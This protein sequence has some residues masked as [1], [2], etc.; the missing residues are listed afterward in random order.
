MALICVAA[1]YNLSAQAQNPYWPAGGWKLWAT[2]ETTVADAAM[3]IPGQVG[4]MA[5]TALTSRHYP[6]DT[7]VS[8]KFLNY[9]AAEYGGRKYAGFWDDVYFSVDGNADGTPHSY[10][11]GGYWITGNIN[12]TGFNANSW[13]KGYKGNIQSDPGIDKFG[14]NWTSQSTTMMGHDIANSGTDYQYGTLGVEKSWYFKNCL[15]AGPAHISFT[16]KIIDTMDDSYQAL[17]PSYFDSVGS[18]GSEVHGLLKMMIAGG[19]L[20][21][22]MKPELKRHGIYIATMLYIWKASLPYDAPYDSELRHRVAYSTNGDSYIAT[23]STHYNDYWHMYNEIDHMANMVAMAKTMTVAPPITLIK[24]VAVLSGTKTYFNKT[25]ALIQQAA[26]QQG[27][28][29]VSLNDSYDIASRP[30]TFRAK[31]LYGNPATVITEESPGNYLII[32]P[33]STTLPKGRTTIIFIANNGVYDSNPAVLNFYRTD[34][35]ANKRPVFTWAKEAIVYPGHMASF[36][37]KATDP[38]GFPCVFYKRTQDPGTITGNIYTL[39]TTG[40]AIGSYPIPILFSDSTSGTAGT[41][42][43]IT[44]STAVPAAVDELA[45]V[46]A[47]P[48]PVNISTGT[49]AKIIGLTGNCIVEIF[50]GNGT[51]VKEL[52]EAEQLFPNA[53]RVD[54]DGKNENGDI[55]GRG[56]YM[57]VVKSALGNKKTGKIAL[58]K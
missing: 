12:S 57:F 37:L 9:R 22:A 45:Q 1:A 53:G 7:A 13:L 43:T 34:G 24:E 32:V 36:E 14:V 5:T 46:K 52:K 19:Y 33:S 44:V 3:K 23:G 35:A 50:D 10:M 51:K 6:D 16:E 21:I 25:A 55:V 11:A 30:L 15:R 4:Q 47:Y 49:T 42:I 41:D 58:L 27:M 38:E 40:L 26:G 29:R 56:M 54:W 17:V 31:L 2:D 18:S 8:G 20:P 28:V 48:N 39:D